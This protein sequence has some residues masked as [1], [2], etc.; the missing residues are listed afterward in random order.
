MRLNIFAI[1]YLLRLNAVKYF[2]NSN[3]KIYRT[4]SQLNVT[5]MDLT[6]QMSL[7]I[8]ALL[9][10]FLLTTCSNSYQFADEDAG[11]LDEV[12]PDED[13]ELR[14]DLDLG[15]EVTEESLEPNVTLPESDHSS[16]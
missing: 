10:F 16:P 12:A 11:F 8:C 2:P 13:L 4:Y 3:T 6:F 1:K 9:K 5:F 7:I 15:V 14:G